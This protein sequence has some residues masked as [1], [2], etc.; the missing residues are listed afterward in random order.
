MA[1]RSATSTTPAP[2]ASSDPASSARPSSV[3]LIRS[4]RAGSA[5]TS[6]SRTASACAAHDRI[7]WPVSATLSDAICGIS[8]ASCS[9]N[10]S[11]V[12]SERLATIACT[13]PPDS[14]PSSHAC[15]VTGHAR[16]RRAVRLSR[17]AS[18]DGSDARS[19]SHA[20]SDVAASTSH[21]PARSNSPSASHTLAA[22]SSM[23][24]SAPAI[25]SP[26]TGNSNA[27][28]DSATAANDMPLSY[29][30]SS[31]RPVPICTLLRHLHFAET[32]TTS[33]CHDPAAWLGESCTRGRSGS[34]TRRPT[35]RARTTCPCPTGRS[36]AS[37]TVCAA[38]PVPGAL[39]PRHGHPHRP[40][41][42][43]HRG[44]RRGPAR[45]RG[46]GMRSWRS[47]TPRSHADSRLV[48]WGGGSGAP[49]R[50]GARRAAWRVRYGAIGLDAG[51][52]AAPAQDGD[53]SV[54]RYLL[55][56]WP[57]PADGRPDRPPGQP[58]SGLLA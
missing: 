13:C 16:R 48:E 19:R 26:S 20:T 4:V 46:R 49:S 14:P 17:A 15:R 38:R 51:H 6:A 10:N 29:M 45:R 44:A 33:A 37:G 22:N 7:A 32:A 42:L 47:P 35:C 52:G 41:R 36:P 31:P 40:G 8:S 50:P 21:R 54:D 3:R 11:T 23:A 1:S 43:H 5:G 9:A 39:L 55:Q 2:S 30:C 53:E 28:I 56:F 58:A 57:A 25:A 12:R 34:R 24:A 27:R 18:R